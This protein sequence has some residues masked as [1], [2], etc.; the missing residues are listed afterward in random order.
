VSHP[1]IRAVLEE[2]TKL[3]SR[4]K[5]RL[6]IE[7]LKVGSDQPTATDKQRLAW[8]LSSE[9]PNY[10]LIAEQ[11]EIALIDKWCE[12]KIQSIRFAKC[13]LAGLSEPDNPLLWE[14]EAGFLTQGL[15]DSI[16]LHANFLMNLW[17][18]VSFKWDLF[19]PYFPGETPLSLFQVM[20]AEI[21]NGTFKKYLQPYYS[22]NNNEFRE[23]FRLKTAESKGAFLTKEQA[24]RLAYLNRLHSA[25]QTIQPK[26]FELAC[27]FGRRDRFIAAK[28]RAGD[29]LQAGI[30]RINKDLAH[31]SRSLFASE[32]Y[33]RGARSNFIRHQRPL[34]NS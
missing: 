29:Q 4:S 12:V 3:Q 5:F 10:S 31:Q 7:W 32:T 22:R 18:L 14:L 17:E 9:L 1:Y 15:H 6:S 20:F 23:L 25:P 33:V 13:L 21:V 16:W 28:I 24:K 30:S 26:I 19:R 27:E 8:F 11:D 34:N 2:V